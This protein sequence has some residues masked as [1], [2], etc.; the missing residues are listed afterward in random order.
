MEKQINRKGFK[1]LMLLLGI[2]SMIFI[3]Q[4]R[5]IGIF[6]WLAPVFLLQFSRKAKPLEFFILFLFLVVAGYITQQTHN[7]FNDL[8]FGV[9]NGVAFALVFTATYL[10]DRILYKTEKS[11]LYTLIFPTVYV[12]VE[13]IVTLKLGIS[14][15]LGISQFS[16]KPFIQLSTITGVHGIAFIICWFASIV[17]WLTESEFKPP[18]LKKGLIWF[19]SVFILILSFGFVKMVSQSEAPQKVKVATVSGPFDLLQ[20]AKKEKTVL[21]QLS[22]NPE[23]EIPESFFSDDAEILIQIENTR[24]AAEAGA[25]IIVWNEAALFL[26]QKQLSS[27]LTR[28]KRI[29][30]EFKAYIL[31]AFFEENISLDIKPIN[32]KSILITKDGTI[33]WEYKKVYPTPVE[34]SLVNAGSGTIPTFETEYGK[35]GSVIC[36]DYDFPSFL[37]QAN[38]NK[39]DIMLVP[40]YDWKEFAHMH[41][42]MAR[43]ETLQSGRSLIRANGNGGINTVV[44]SKGNLI[45]KLISVTGDKRILYADLP[46]LATPTVYAKTTNVFES[47]C[48]VLFLFFIVV[49]IRL[50]VQSRKS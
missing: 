25:K 3:G 47:V 19:G 29:S 24:K 33:G 14:G 35:L 13:V 46:M 34:M 48:V 9:I 23:M 21:I 11:F 22:K 17:Y 20:L 42:K 31:I 15:V 12:L 2:V 18:F 28:V 41:S 7:M 32:N 44:D 16:F 6:A 27:V 10:I 8:A 30:K 1:Y 39:V 26:N 45:A 5:Q 4:E 40:A 38:K 36:Y 37:Q 49:R 50:F 43:L